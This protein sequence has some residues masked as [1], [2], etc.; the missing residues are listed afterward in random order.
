MAE[1]EQ[2]GWAG[3]LVA[4]LLQWDLGNGKHHNTILE[5]NGYLTLFSKHLSFLFCKLVEYLLPPL[6][7]CVQHLAAL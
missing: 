6:L 4:S 2:L 3:Y 5:P 1:G 7:P